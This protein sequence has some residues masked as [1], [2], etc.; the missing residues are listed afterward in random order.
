LDIVSSNAKVCARVLKTSESV[1]QLEWSDETKE[2][3]EAPAPVLG[4]EY[5]EQRIRWTARELS[6]Y[7]KGLRHLHE[8]Q[9]LV[10]SYFRQSGGLCY[11]QE[12]GIVLFGRYASADDVFTSI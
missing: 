4:E 8:Y 6:N 5:V 9:K 10:L 2:T 1:F 3:E 11:G 7:R 12:L